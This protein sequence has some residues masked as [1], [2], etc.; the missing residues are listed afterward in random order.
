M[1][2]NRPPV[3][4]GSTRRGQWLEYFTIAYN[5]LEGLVSIVAGLIARSVS[6][7]DMCR[8]GVSGA[9]RRNPCDL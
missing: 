8:N 3:N 6:L 2:G 7:V 4:S 9:R 1:H 5:C